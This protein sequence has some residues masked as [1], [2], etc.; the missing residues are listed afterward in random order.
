MPLKIVPSVAKILRDR[1]L[2]VSPP[3]WTRRHLELVACHFVDGNDDSQRVQEHEPEP[4]DAN[5]GES[6][7]IVTYSRLLVTCQT[8]EDCIYLFEAT[9]TSDFL[10]MLAQPDRVEIPTEGLTINHRAVPFEPE[11]SFRQRL[12]AELLDTSR[13]TCAVS[14]SG[15]RAESTPH[16]TKRHRSPEDEVKRRA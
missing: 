11:R 16:M 2:F 13:P 12:M 5:N 8:E 15:E 14:R 10:R 6:S 1:R 3:L 9:I 4:Q 7:A